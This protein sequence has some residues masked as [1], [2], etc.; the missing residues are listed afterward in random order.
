LTTVSK[1]L[2]DDVQELILKAGYTS[3]VYQPRSPKTSN[4]E[5]RKVVGKHVSYEVNWLKNSN[6]HN[7]SDKGLAPHSI[8][9]WE[10]YNGKVYC[11]T[12]PNHLL[13]VRRNGKPVW[14]GNSLRFYMTAETDEME[15]LIDEAESASAIT[16]EYCGQ[17]GKLRNTGWLFTLCD[18]CDEER[19]WRKR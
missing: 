6:S 11:A 8:E 13:Y 17:P 12:V 16:C 5:G 19:P 10:S 4:L 18:K 7:T 14:C 3:R 2:A 1:R 9:C 15:K